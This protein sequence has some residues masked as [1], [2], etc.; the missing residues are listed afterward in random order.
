MYHTHSIDFPTYLP[1]G[2]HACGGDGHFVIEGLE[3]HLLLGRG[4][5]GRGREGRG[6]RGEEA[7]NHVV[8]HL[9]TQRG[10]GEEGK[11]EGGR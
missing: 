11:E 5:G 6:D 9:E 8:Q 7:V 2:D 10:R 3:L 1:L 4:Q